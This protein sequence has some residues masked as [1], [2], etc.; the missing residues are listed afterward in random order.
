MSHDIELLINEVILESCDRI[1]TAAAF[2]AHNGPAFA[3]RGEDLQERDADLRDV[4]TWG[5]TE[6]GF[7]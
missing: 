4:V 1:A 6:S 3:Q 5:S 2:P 7:Q